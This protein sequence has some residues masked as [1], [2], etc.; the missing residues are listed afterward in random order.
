VTEAAMFNPAA[1]GLW[2]WRAAFCASRWLHAT[3]RF[4]SQ[5]PIRVVALH[6]GHVAHV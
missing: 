4:H 1:S 6:V 3:Y 5:L 2:A